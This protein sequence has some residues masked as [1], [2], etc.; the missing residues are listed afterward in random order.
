MRF[1]ATI[2]LSSTQRIQ[3]EERRV[4]KE[5]SDVCSSDL[6]EGLQYKLRMMGVPIEGPYNVFCNNNAVVIATNSDP[7]VDDSTVFCLFEYHYI[8]ALFTEM[9]TPVCNLLVTRHPA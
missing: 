8:G 7:N 9:S 5:C 2:Q 6:I 4:G 3:I 1:A